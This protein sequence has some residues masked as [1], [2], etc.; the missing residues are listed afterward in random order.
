MQYR[1][2]IHNI[3]GAQYLISG[4]S[5]T[6]D[7][8]FLSKAN[9]QL[10]GN[11]FPTALNGDRK[12]NISESS[13]LFYAGINWE[14]ITGESG[15]HSQILKKLDR[16]DL[17][18][19]YGPSKL[20][21][22]SVWNGF[23]NYRGAIQADGDAL[24]EVANEYG[25]SLAL[26]N[27][28]HVIWEL[29]SMRFSEAFA[30]RNLLIS[31]KHPALDF[32]GD[33]VFQIPLGLSEEAELDFI[34]KAIRWARSNVEL[35]RNRAETAARL[36]FERY[37]LEHQLLE[38]IEAFHAQTAQPRIQQK[39]SYKQFLLLDPH[40][41]NYLEDLYLALDN[42]D[43]DFILHSKESV[44]WM[45]NNFGYFQEKSKGYS[46]ILANVSLSDGTNSHIHPALESYSEQGPSYFVAESLI[47]STATLR[48]MSDQMPLN[49][50][51]LFFEQLLLGFYGRGLCLG[52]LITSSNVTYR[53]SL[54]ISIK[55]EL[56]VIRPG[57]IVGLESAMTLSSQRQK[58]SQK[59]FSS[60]SAKLPARFKDAIRPF[61]IRVVK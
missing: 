59:Y 33:L 60:V 48:G 44:Q 21:G 37:S 38:L 13:K 5:N 50:K 39:S 43:I 20:R 36:W 15:R 11:L 58:L 41:K 2:G 49:Y 40:S 42:K 28:Q 30:A 55:T 54:K 8:Y 9:I 4:G 1:Y 27:P 46:F 26:L 14:R 16:V 34:G 32:L 7:S 18:D 22:I 17:V 53:F 19:L 6:T 57:P 51:S 10:I 45:Q 56:S 31:N 29:V 24:V 47:L 35:A 12:S 23:K 61:W 25:I 3:L 52:D